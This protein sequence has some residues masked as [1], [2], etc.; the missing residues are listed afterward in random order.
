MLVSNVSVLARASF[1]LLFKGFVYLQNEKQGKHVT[2]LA[3]YQKGFM[4]IQTPFKSQM[5]F[6]VSI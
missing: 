4:K 3:L 6:L 2:V 1:V 5:I